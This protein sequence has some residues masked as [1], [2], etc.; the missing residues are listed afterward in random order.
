MVVMREEEMMMRGG[1]DSVYFKI[2]DWKEWGKALSITNNSP[3]YTGQW[4]VEWGTWHLTA[5]LNYIDLKFVT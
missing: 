4:I 1:A 5:A 3:S 2:F